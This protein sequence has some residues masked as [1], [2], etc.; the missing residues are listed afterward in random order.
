M[1]T[2]VIHSFFRG[3]STD[4]RLYLIDNSP[5]DALS[6][7]K[8]LYPK[9]TEYIFLNENAGYGKAHNVAIR[10]S[11]EEGF[12]YHVV[13]NP[14]LSF[15]GEVIP[16]LEEF[17]DNNCMVGLCI[18]DVWD[19]DYEGRR[20]QARLLPSPIH[21]ILRRFATNWSYTK[22]LDD[23]YILRFADFSKVMDIPYISGCFMF[24]RNSSLKDVGLFD[25]K[26]FMYYEDVDISRRMYS[27]YRCCFVPKVKA[28]HKGE[29]AT[30]KSA[31]MLWITIKS[32]LYYFHKYGFIF[33]SER[34]K[35]NAEVLS[36]VPRQN[37][38]GG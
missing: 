6:E 34:R 8:E 17:M 32:A 19:L 28:Y 24:F 9:Q 38:L 13:L 21:A 14:D 15:G 26:I 5:T 3:D 1:V 27:K 29:R 36:K 10:K 31:K 23:E 22:Q 7:L 12:D 30:Y 18:P 35:I 11:M 2:E 16:G 25:E 33:D 4:R 20:P 37:Q